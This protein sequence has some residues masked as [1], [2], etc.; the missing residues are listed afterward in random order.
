MSFARQFSRWYIVLLVVTVVGLGRGELQLLFTGGWLVA[1]LLLLVSARG[2]QLLMG[3]TRGFSRRVLAGAAVTQFPGM[4]L[5]GISLWLIFHHHVSEWINGLL[6]IWTA[7]LWPLWERLPP[8]IVHGLSLAY[9]AACCTPWA[10]FLTV[11]GFA[12]LLTKVHRRF[13][14][15]G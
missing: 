12:I 11:S 14:R 8:V 4:A 9:I 2:Q 13:S 15:E 5:S 1:V 10:L 3:Q 6:E 7:P